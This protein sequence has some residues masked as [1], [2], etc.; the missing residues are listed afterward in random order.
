M[1]N[2]A[3]LSKWKWRCLK[4]RHAIWYDLLS[5]RYG[6]FPSKILCRNDNFIARKD[7]LWWRDICTVGG[8]RGDEVGWFP[9]NVNSVLGNG[10]SIQFWQEKWIGGAPLCFVYPQLY[11]LERY[12]EIMV[13]DRGIWNDGQWRWQWDWLEEL[14]IA[15]AD[16]L[17]EL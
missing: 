4:E 17:A 9:S 10:L 7:S 11:R 1:F 3:L 15:E 5:F 16:E 13:A 12:K 2:H 6:P 8:R 14:S